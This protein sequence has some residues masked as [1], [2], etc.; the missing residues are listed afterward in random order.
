MVTRDDLF[1]CV[2]WQAINRMGIL[3]EMHNVFQQNYL[4]LSSVHF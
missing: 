4:E 2:G 3:A 1:N